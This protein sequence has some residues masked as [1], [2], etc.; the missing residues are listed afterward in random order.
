MILIFSEILEGNKIVLTNVSETDD[1]QYECIADNGINPPAR[2][3]TKVTVECK[4][5]NF[6]ESL[7]QCQ[8]ILSP[9]SMLNVGH[10]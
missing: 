8:G 5:L 10:E 3:S 7:S 6:T 4:S 9:M 1:G 2:E